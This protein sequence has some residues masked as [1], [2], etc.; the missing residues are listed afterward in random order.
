MVGGQKYLSV[1]FEVFGV[2]Q[3]VFFRKYTREEATRLHLV[4]FCRNT[5]RRTVE[6]VAVGLEGS[7]RAFQNWLE[8][9]GSPMSQIARCEFS[10]EVVTD[11]LHPFTEFEIR[12]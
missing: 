6:G 2:V 1:R 9:T 3:G 4:G 11:T 7:V 10:D 8:T 12:R 5:A